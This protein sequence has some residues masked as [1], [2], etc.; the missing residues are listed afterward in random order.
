MTAH[1]DADRGGNPFDLSDTVTGPDG[2]RRYTGLPASLVEMLAERARSHPDAEAVVEVGGAR[3][4][5]RQLWDGSARVAGGLRDQ[6][7]RHGDRVAILLPSGLDWVLGFLGCILA[8][9]IAVPVNTRLTPAEVDAVIGDAE[10]RLI[11]APGTDLPDGA[12]YAAAG[13][14][15]TDVAAIFYTSGT[16]GEPKGALQTHEGFL[17]NAENAAR[18]FSFDRDLG[19][20]GL[21]TLIAV[22]LFHVT[23][24]HTQ[25]V[26]S[27][28]LHGTAVILP[29]LDVGRFLELI[30]QER[31]NVLIAVP[32]IYKLVISRP[33]FAGTDV[34][35]VRW[36]GYGGAP[37]SP[38]LVREIEQAFPN[39][40]LYNCFGSTE[41][42]SLTSVLPG[43]F[44][45]EF[46]ESVGFAVPV[47]D[48]ALDEVDD[49]TGVG[50]LLVRGPNVVPGYWR[51]PQRSADAIRDGWLHTGDL[52]RIENG[53]I[54]LADRA[55][56]VINRGG[57]KVYSIEVETALA[58]LDGIAESA[59]VGVPDDV[60]GEKVGAVIVRAPGADP[61]P[62][63]IVN[64]LR[65]RIADYKIP[66]YVVV[67]D[68]PLPRNPGGKVRKGPVKTD[69]CWGQALR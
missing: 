67:R 16:T 13:L 35:A 64:F 49:L 28:Y 7:V 57:E 17:S 60:M 45:V 9:A 6:G 8:G 41:S 50:E 63:K 1:L 24:C 40:A 69:T 33:E 27:L 2:I 10:A 4:S 30:P 32:A 38:T 25:L 26:L 34:S 31:I 55:K 15:H 29:Q 61:T 20:A 43:R 11:L 19:P 22:P 5:Y 48:L 39:G 18:G 66:Q 46:I 23:G 3:L 54:Y 56:D 65:E 12:P 51:K 52:A 44:A 42:S 59:V 68:E 36:I 58:A 62:E 47:V 53:L 37:T 14:S 21:R